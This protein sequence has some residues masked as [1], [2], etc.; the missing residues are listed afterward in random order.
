[1]FDRYARAGKSL[2]V[3]TKGNYWAGR[4]ARGRPRHETGNTYYQQAAAYPELFYGQLALERLG[5][6]VSAPHQ[7]LPQYVTTLLQRTAF[8][9][10]P[11]VQAV[12]VLGQQNRPTEQA[13]S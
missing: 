4:A 9:S 5:R 6:T 13:C 1:M 10:R 7:A 3:Q 8:N 11:L 12:R 2:Q